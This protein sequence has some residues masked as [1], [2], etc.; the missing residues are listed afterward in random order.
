MSFEMYTAAN[1]Y[2]PKEEPQLTVINYSGGKQSSALVWMVLNGDLP[3]PKNLVVLNADP[4]MENSLTYEY[5]KTIFEACE[6]QGIPAYTVKGPNLYQDLVG[7]SATDKTRFDNPPYWTKSPEG[8]KG[9]LRQKC[10][11]IYKIAPMDREIRRILEKQFGI[12]QRRKRVPQGIVEKWIG[13]PTNEAHRIKPP[14][15]KYIYFRYP[16]IE[17]GMDSSDVVNYFI[18]KAL[19]IPPR[20]VC[21][22][23]FA[24]GL[25]TFQEMYKNRPKDWEQAVTVD[26]AVRSLTQIGIKEEV[27]VSS[28]L[29]SLEALA[30]DG[31]NVEADGDQYSCD[32]GYCFL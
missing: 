9:R 4:G 2:E 20:S 29:K 25:S 19:P 3:R 5:H 30:T 13:F 26:R 7:L 23:C 18:D 14:S 32:S 8:K 22:A 6:A 12:S 27:F 15:Q 28:A 10:T 11:G 1:G 21:N 16:L 31:F 17:L 24:N